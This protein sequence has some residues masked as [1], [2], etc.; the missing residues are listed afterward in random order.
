MSSTVDSNV[1]DYVTAATKAVL[2]M[3]PFAGSL[4]AELAGTII[5]NQRIDRISRFSVELEGRLSGMDQIL[6]RTNL[7]DENFTD[8]LETTARQAAQALTKERLQYLASLVANGMDRE[9]LSFIESKQ[10]LRLL[11]EINDVE[12]VWLRFYLHPYM[13]GDVEFREKHK[14][15]LAPITAEL[16]ADQA[17]RDKRAL[18]T[19][20]QQHLVSLGLLERPLQVDQKTGAPVYDRST[21]DWKHKGHQLTSLGGLVLRQIGFPE[22]TT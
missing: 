21:N 9:R 20:Y 11:G 12:V 22:E 19:N 15:V 4:L 14:M 5:P 3:V 8:L 10:I 7:L 6:I 17:T 1:I 16:G 18:Q 13:S 2:G